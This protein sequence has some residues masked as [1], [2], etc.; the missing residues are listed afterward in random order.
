MSVSVCVC[1]SLRVCRSKGWFTRVAQQ[2]LFAA[3]DVQP[4]CS[5]SEAGCAELKLRTRADTLI[6]ELPAGTDAA[7]GVW[8]HPRCLDVAA[9]DHICR[10]AARVCKHG[11]RLRGVGMAH[12]KKNASKFDIQLKTREPVT[13]QV[14]GSAP[15]ISATLDQTC[16]P[17]SVLRWPTARGHT[18]A[19]TNTR[20]SVQIIYFFAFVFFLRSAWSRGLFLQEAPG[21]GAAH[22]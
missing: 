7:A 20:K 14:D 5:L 15:F 22:D 19:H 21:G 10:R 17:P 2:R 11:C 18:R 8:L 12:C 6:Y 3:E 9:V 16:S 4:V 13:V 1:V